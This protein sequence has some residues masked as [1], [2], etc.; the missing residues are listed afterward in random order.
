MYFLLQGTLEYHIILT[1]NSNC[2]VFWCFFYQSGHQD[3]PRSRC[4]LDEGVCFYRAGLCPFFCLS[5]GFAAH[6]FA[7][8][9]A[10]KVSPLQRQGVNRSFVRLRTLARV[11]ELADAPDLGSGGQ[12]WGFDSPLSHHLMSPRRRGITRRACFGSLHRLKAR[13]VF[14]KDKINADMRNAKGKVKC[15]TRTTTS[16]S[17]SRT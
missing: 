7:R 17:N 1:R 11:A 9:V 3:T 13:W 2:L 12:P 8:S 5:H 16:G 15:R 10:G 6:G 14:Q 4:N